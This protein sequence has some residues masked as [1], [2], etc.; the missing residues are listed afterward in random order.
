LYCLSHYLFTV[1][2]KTTGGWDCVGIR[3]DLG[4]HNQDIQ[5]GGDGGGGSDI[6]DMLPIIL[7]PSALLPGGQLP[8]PPSAWDVYYFTPGGGL[9][10]GTGG[11][12]IGSIDPWKSQDAQKLVEL[13]GK[14]FAPEGYF[15]EHYW[16]KPDY[17][18][19]SYINPPTSDKNYDQNGYR[20]NGQI[21]IYSDG[22]RTKFYK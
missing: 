14:E 7:P 22:Y 19:N 8:S 10:A 4:S 9:Q 3:I 15:Q 20:K 2:S 21:Y 12:Q 13:D 6:G 16:E 5:P 1:P 11:S 18:D 17:D